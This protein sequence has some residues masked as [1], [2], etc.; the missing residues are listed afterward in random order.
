MF[1]T[2]KRQGAMPSTST[3]KIDKGKEKVVDEEEDK[4]ETEKKFNLFMLTVMM[5]MR[6]GSQAGSSKSNM[7]KLRICKPI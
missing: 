7:P 5:K 4:H 1:A 2:L 3:K 6:K